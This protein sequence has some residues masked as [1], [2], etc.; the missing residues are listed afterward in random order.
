MGD[1]S[2]DLYLTLNADTRCPAALRVDG[3]QK[4]IADSVIRNGGAVEF[5]SDRCEV[6][7]NGMFILQAVVQWGSGSSGTIAG[8]ALY[9]R[10]IAEAHT[11]RK[12]E[13]SL[14]ASTE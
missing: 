9:E 10:L 4:F 6:Y 2:S 13:N 11:F 3:V 12:K 1:G 5:P 8:A 7:G 14:K